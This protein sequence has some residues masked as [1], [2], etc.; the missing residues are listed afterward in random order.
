[1]KALRSLEAYIEHARLTVRQPFFAGGIADAALPAW[2][3]TTTAITSRPVEKEPACPNRTH[4][5][6]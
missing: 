3:A 5:A 6:V 2:V 4:A 1:M